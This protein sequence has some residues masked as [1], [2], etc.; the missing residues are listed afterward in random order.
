MFV[1]EELR[2]LIGDSRDITSAES[3][4]CQILRAVEKNRRRA[5]VGI[6]AWLLDKLVRLLGAG[7]QPLVIF[8]ARRLLRQKR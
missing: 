2:L 5:L 6:D 4:V 3:A 8:L 7:Y 1:D